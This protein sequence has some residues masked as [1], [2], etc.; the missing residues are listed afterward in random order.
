MHPT[1]MTGVQYTQ[2]ITLMTWSNVVSI[3]DQPADLIDYFRSK[4][5]TF[6]GLDLYFQTDGDICV[7]YASGAA[8]QINELCTDGEDFTGSYMLYT[9]VKKSTGLEVCLLFHPFLHR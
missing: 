3:S 4:H 2:D 9:V 5:G 1:G 8:T 6:S 7:R